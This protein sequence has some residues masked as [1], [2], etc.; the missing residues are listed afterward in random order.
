MK[1]VKYCGVGQLEYIDIPKPTVQAGQALVKIIYCGICGTDIHAY[2]HPGS[3]TGNWY[4]V[5]RLWEL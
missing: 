2:S 3:L 4:W 5:M 1:A